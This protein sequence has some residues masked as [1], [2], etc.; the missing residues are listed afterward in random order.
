MIVVFAAKVSGNA[1]KD[2]FVWISRLK[3]TSSSVLAQNRKTWTA[4]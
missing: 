2:V 1:G 3:I 4:T